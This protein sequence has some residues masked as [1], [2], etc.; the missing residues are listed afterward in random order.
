MKEINVIS[1]LIY[2]AKASLLYV[3]VLA[4][5]HGA[6]G[7]I[8]PNL[9][10][11]AS[12]RVHFEEAPLMF[13]S[14]GETKLESYEAIVPSLLSGGKTSNVRF[15]NRSTLLTTSSHLFLSQQLNVNGAK[16]EQ[17]HT[18][19]QSTAM[20]EIIGNGY[21]WLYQSTVDGT[22][23]TDMRSLMTFPGLYKNDTVGIPRLGAEF[24]DAKSNVQSTSATVNGFTIVD[25]MLLYTPNIQAEYPGELAITLLNH[26]I[27]KTNQ[28]FINSDIAVQL[29]LV[30]IE[31]VNYTQPSSITALNDIEAVLDDDEST[32]GATS[33]FNIAAWRDEVGAD[34]V[35]MIRTHDLN[36]REVCGIAMF[37]NNQTDVLANVSNVGI[38][39]GSNC[40]NTFTHEIGHNF[41]AGHQAIDGRS[42][43]AL[44][45]SGALVVRGKFNT[46]MSS[47]GTGDENRDF[48]FSVFSNLQH[49]CGGRICGNA[50]FADNASTVEAFAA[51]NA[52][53]R[54]MV[55]PLEDFAEPIA[56]FT[57][58][59][60]DSVDDTQDAFPFL[61]SETADT[62]N[63][64]VGDVQ[65]A[66]PNDDSE[67]LDTDNDGIGNNADDDDDNDGTL[68]ANDDL[69]LNRFET[70]DADGDGIGDNE[71]ALDFDFQE[72]LDA[73]GDNIG[74]L[75]DPDDD[76]DGVLDFQTPTTLAS[77]NIVVVSANTHQILEYDAT[78]GDFIGELL[79]MP[80]GSLTFRS[81]LEVS[82]S[83]QLYFIAFSDVYRY[84]RQQLSV[85]K[86]IDRS[87][88]A[89]NFP[90]HLTF[91]DNFT[92]L[93]NNGLGFSALETFNLSFDGTFPVNQIG[94]SDVFRDTVRFN[95]SL[96]LF[97]NRS[98]NLL[99]LLEDTT[100]V[101][102]PIVFANEGLNKPEHIAINSAG[103]IF[104]SNAGD[105]SISQFSSDGTFLGTFI[106]AGASGLGTPSCLVSGPDDALYICSMDTN[107][108][109]VFSSTSGAFVNRIV[110]ANAGGLNRPV[111]LAFIGKALD[112][113]PYDPNNDSDNDGTPNINDDLP[114]DPS[115]FLDTDRDGIGNM[116]D[117]DDDDDGMPDVW[118]V[119]FGL[120]PLDPSDASTDL[121]GDFVNNLAEFGLGTDPTVRDDLE[122]VQTGSGGSFNISMLITLFLVSVFRRR[123]PI[124]SRI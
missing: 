89:T 13:K 86:V 80:E 21:H 104:V 29:R 64:G 18:Q 91:I 2:I 47:I 78:T 98:A 95:D 108:I 82:P 116:T 55:I 68:D 99:Q 67:T 87:E 66:F 53:L 81:D 37:P 25:V 36:E 88:L 38:S 1:Q 76:N 15:S 122:R 103:N 11:V 16:Y 110:A 49:Q 17:F 33:L 70:Q 65:D 9:V 112:D 24:S 14:N 120:N 59:D 73:D 12:S 102:A 32:E 115:D 74:D 71:D 96:V 97:A 62:D 106:Q 63:D 23:I 26:L 39:G 20:G 75:R 31:F 92:L 43:G 40:A 90:V 118:E 30:R 52:A 83:G 60:G 45:N 58:S 6:N 72:S 42:Q 27:A 121:D 123:N 79:S 50:E 48:K 93:V 61:A 28:S 69:P 10:N 44:S 113:A 35:S 109:F 54:E 114:L 41:G 100:D 5:A 107:E 4:S 117:T 94:E 57:D 101:T 46:V 34:I 22:W 105:N 85:K 19:G 8:P 56:I 124:F 51:Q 111:A 119:Q 3:S 7:V 84:D 77:S